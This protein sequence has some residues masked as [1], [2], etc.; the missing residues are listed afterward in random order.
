MFLVIY[1]GEIMTFYENVY[2][3]AQQR[4]LSIKKLAEI[5][6]V[7]DATIYTWKRTGA[8]TGKNMTAVAD[9]L[10]VSV[11]YL[12][13]ES[14]STSESENAHKN[15]I[16]LNEVANNDSWDEYLSADGHPLSD[17]DKQV[18]RALF[19]D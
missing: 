11:G 7:S 10:G 14:N 8:P 18:L 15:I 16:D 4:G 6:G 5:I 19:G 3:T 2:K 1:A 17:K 12:M 9:A 13:G